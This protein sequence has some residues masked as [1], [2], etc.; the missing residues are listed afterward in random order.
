[1]S[2]P[3]KCPKCNSDQLSANKHG[4][5]L[6]KG[7]GGAVI[8]GGIGLLAG[9]HGANRVEITCLKCGHVFRPSNKPEPTEIPGYK[10]PWWVVLL[11]L[12]IVVL[13]MIFY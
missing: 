13:I 4:Y 2:E 12:A 9:M 7:I 11:V 5:S 10:L 6:K 3:I 8:T 1:M